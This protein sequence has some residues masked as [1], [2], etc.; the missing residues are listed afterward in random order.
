MQNALKE[1]FEEAGLG[2]V[3]TFLEPQFTSFLIAAPEGNLL[4]AANKGIIRTNLSVSFCKH[5]RGNSCAMDDRSLE[6]EKSYR[7]SVLLCRS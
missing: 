7:W 1:R 4:L 2:G 5:R 3:F 6:L